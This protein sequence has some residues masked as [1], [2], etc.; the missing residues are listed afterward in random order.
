MAADAVDDF[1]P[2]R[3]AENLN[4][5]AL[6][7]P[8]PKTASFMARLKP[9]IFDRPKMKSVLGLDACPELAAFPAQPPRR[10]VLLSEAV[11]AG[12]VGEGGEAG[13]LA[14]LPEEERAWA[15]AEGA[16]PFRRTHEIGYDLM[17]VEQANIINCCFRPQTRPVFLPSFV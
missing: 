12:A 1:D 8:A 3:F 14:G 9:Y 7:I 5:I 4:L 13:L 11:S 16:M 6:A 15:V 2:A 10:A 17:T